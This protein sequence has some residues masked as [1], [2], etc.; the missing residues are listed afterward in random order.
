MLRYAFKC[1]Y[2]I[3]V[4]S[5]SLKR[6]HLSYITYY[7]IEY[8]FRFC[9]FNASFPLTKISQRSL[10]TPILASFHGLPVKFRIHLKIDRSS[11]TWPGSG[12]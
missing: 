12:I 5:R 9:F 8:G 6:R 3:N 1:A 11:P 2:P 7:L 4:I 10:I